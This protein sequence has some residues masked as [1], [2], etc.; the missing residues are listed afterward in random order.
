MAALVLVL[1]NHIAD[2]EV[3]TEAIALVQRLP[4]AG[5]AQSVEFSPKNDNAISA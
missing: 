2:E 1:I 5:R 4:H 3:V